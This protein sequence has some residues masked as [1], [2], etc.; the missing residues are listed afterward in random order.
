MTKHEREMKLIDISLDQLAVLLMGTS[1]PSE[2][3]GVYLK[4]VAR[5][6]EKR[7]KLDAMELVDVISY[8]KFSVSGNY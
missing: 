6:V 1:E 2:L 7:R 5:L 4:E 8:N 3:R